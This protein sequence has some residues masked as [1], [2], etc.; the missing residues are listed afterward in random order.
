MKILLVNYEYPPLGGGGGIAMMEIAE[1]LATRHSVHVLTSGAPGLEAVSRHPSVDLT[2]HRAPVLA[3]R[4]DRA[5]AS[6]LSMLG[7]LPSGIRLGNRLFDQLQFDVVN[8]WFAIP[9]GVTGGWLAKKH[10]VPHVLTVI[11]G[12]IY[13]PSKWY[14]PHHFSPSGSAVKWA[15]RHADEHVAISSDIANRT[16]EYFR[17]DKNIDVI[18]LGIRKPRFGEV[19][20]EHLKLLPGR[21]YIVTVGRLVRRKDYPTLI[22]AISVLDRADVDLLM[23]GDGPEHQNLQAL[24]NELG[25]GDRVRFLGFVSNEVKYQV[26][27]NSD[28]FVLASLHEGFGVVYLEAMFCG[29]PIIAANQGGQV[30]ILDDGTTGGLVDI[31]NVEQMASAIRTLIDD[32]DLRSKIGHAN[33]I[34]AE[35]YSIS[36]IAERY[37]KIFENA[38]LANGSSV[39]AAK[40][41]VPS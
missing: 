14:S 37:E 36:R 19:T 30:D 26:L 13:D 28:L 6:F 35:N 8:T 20:R 18:P 23:I 33:R 29:L 21:R 38:A 9:S 17:F 4:H 10:R 22:R 12:D 24:A 16:R 2:V 1:E 25:V 27:A 41:K 40:S 34:R 39:L 31:G 7:F 32:P 3:R 11:G 5:T 15:L